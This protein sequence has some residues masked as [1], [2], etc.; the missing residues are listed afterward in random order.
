MK[1]LNDASYCYGEMYELS[2]V[3]SN[4]EKVEHACNLLANINMKMKQ[5]EKA[6]QAFL[7]CLKYKSSSVQNV[8]VGLVHVQLSECYVCMKDYARA[9]SHLLEYQKIA[10]Q[11][12]HINHE[13]EVK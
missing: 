8:A 1:R 6:A 5:Y 4:R 7:L 2:K 3:H 13:N 12:N 11:G 10:K 9:V